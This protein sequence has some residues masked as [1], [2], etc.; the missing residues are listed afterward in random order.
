MASLILQIGVSVHTKIFP[1]SNFF[2]KSPVHQQ[3]WQSRMCVYVCVETVQIKCMNSE[4]Y[5]V[6]ATMALR[7]SLNHSDFKRPLQL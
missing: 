7:S 1:V 4:D 2:T 5:I 6:L 3:L